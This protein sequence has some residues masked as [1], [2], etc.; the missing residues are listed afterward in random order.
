MLVTLNPRMAK[1]TLTVHTYYTN[2]KCLTSR[3][4]FKNIFCVLCCIFQI[5]YNTDTSLWKR[6]T[7]KKL[8]QNSITKDII[9]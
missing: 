9:P 8:S 6:K 4:W 7:N 1:K 3:W 2:S 5:D